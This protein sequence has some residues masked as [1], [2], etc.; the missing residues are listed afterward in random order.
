MVQGVACHSVFFCFLFLFKAIV[1]SW[2]W[3]FPRPTWGHLAV[4]RDIFGCHDWGGEWILWAE[5]RDATDHPTTHGM[6]PQRE[7]PS[8]GCP[9]G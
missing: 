2:A 8:S 6:A 1:F 4:S 7:R 3:P 9:Q 5:A